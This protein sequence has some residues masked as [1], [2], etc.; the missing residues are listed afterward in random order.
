MIKGWYFAEKLDASHSEGLK[1]WWFYKQTLTLLVPKSVVS[2][3]VHSIKSVNKRAILE[4]LHIVWLKNFAQY[5]FQMSLDL[6]VVVLQLTKLNWGDC[7]LYNQLSITCLKFILYF[8]PNYV[9]P[10][11]SYCNVSP[12]ST[13]KEHN[14]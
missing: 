5:N 2:C 1:D 11:P 13:K 9:F 12:C 8:K 14:M 10:S 3:T 7:G 4:L 6:H